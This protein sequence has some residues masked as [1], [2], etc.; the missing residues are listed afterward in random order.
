MPPRYPKE[1]DVVTVT[2]TP[3]PITLGEGL[4]D[5]RLHDLQRVAEPAKERAHPRRPEP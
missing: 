5:P 1:P 4:L 2:R 3:L